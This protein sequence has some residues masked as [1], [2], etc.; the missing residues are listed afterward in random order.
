MK[1][2]KKLF[3]IMIVFLLVFETNYSMIKIEICYIEAV[4]IEKE[5][6]KLKKI[7]RNQML[8]MNSELESQHIWDIA[9]RYGYVGRYQLGRLA[10]MDMG[11]DTIWINQL[12]NSIYKENNIYKFDLTLFPPNKQDEAILK[13]L[14]RIEKYYLSDI[15]KN[16]VDTEINGVKI[17]K[18]G[19][20]S[21]SFLGFSSVRK[22]V[23]SNGKI[24]PSDGNGHT[25]KD[26]LKIF[27][28][29]ELI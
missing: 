20:L 5:D 22:F 16:Y 26:R 24:N 13:Y 7:T 29:Y 15:L 3:L 1:K 17:T 27:E 14:R 11:Y 4:F 25:V 23:L 2:F 19:I 12:Q 18:A 21:A 8:K 9:N 28:N 10:L 6:N